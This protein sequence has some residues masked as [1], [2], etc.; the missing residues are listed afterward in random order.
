MKQKA[1]GSK[2]SRLCPVS[3]ALSEEL[4]REAKN[5]GAYGHP[6][7]SEGRI[8]VRYFLWGQ[9]LS[10]AQLPEAGVK[11]L[12]ICFRAEG[13][14]RDRAGAEHFASLKR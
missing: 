11:H 2:V 14:A 12:L 1:V 8:P 9:G 10:L 6:E 3:S 4:G 5:G 13:G 7:T